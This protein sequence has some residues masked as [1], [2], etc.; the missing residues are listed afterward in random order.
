MPTRRRPRYVQPGPEVTGRIEGLAK[1]MLDKAIANAM[2][3]AGSCPGMR[4]TCG[5]SAAPIAA[6]VDYKGMGS[7]GPR[8]TT[9]DGRALLLSAD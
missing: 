7:G 4:D 5:V 3:R 9:P 1:L 6:V 8:V 2:A